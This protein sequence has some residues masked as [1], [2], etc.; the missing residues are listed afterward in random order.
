MNC[1]CGNTSRNP[2]GRRRNTAPGRSPRNSTSAPPASQLSSNSDFLRADGPLS[3]PGAH[4]EERA[5]GQKCPPA[6]MTKRS[7]NLPIHRASDRPAVPST[8]TPRPSAAA[9]RCVP[10]NNDRTHNAGC[11]SSPSCQQLTAAL[12]CSPMP[13]MNESIG[14]QDAALPIVLGIE[15]Q[16][17]HDLRRDPSGAH[18]IPRDYALIHD[19]HVSPARPSMCVRRRTRPDR[20]RRSGHH[21]VSALMGDT[22]VHASSESCY[23]CRTRTP[24][25]TAASPRS[26]TRHANRP[27]TSAAFSRD[28]RSN[29]RA[30]LSRRLL[31]KRHRQSSVLA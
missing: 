13:V 22:D 25:G 15:S 17:L 1:P 5:T 28:T 10:V 4:R 29:M 21:E 7:R 23:W 27:D 31:A 26:R 24:P 6:P 18:L 8:S 19:E 3:C 14:L 11:R 2:S 12:A 16:L 9:R 30:T 20:P